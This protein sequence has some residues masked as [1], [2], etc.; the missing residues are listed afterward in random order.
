MKIFAALSLLSFLAAPSAVD[1][2]PASSTL[3]PTHTPTTTRPKP[4]STSSAFEEGIE[5]LRHCPK[6]QGKQPTSCPH[7]YRCSLRRATATAT[8][9]LTRPASSSDRVCE[10]IS[11][12]S[13]AQCNAVALFSGR[14][15]PSRPCSDGTFMDGTVC[16]LDGAKC[17]AVYIACPTT[18]TSTR[19]TFQAPSAIKSTPTPTQHKRAAEDDEVATLL[20]LIPTDAPVVD[21]LA[22]V[23]LDPALLTDVASIGLPTD[24]G[25]WSTDVPPSDAMPTDWVDPATDSGSAQVIGGE[26]GA[27]FGDMPLPGDLAALSTF[28]DNALIPTALPTELP[29]VV[30]LPPAEPDG[31]VEAT[32]AA[33]S[34]TDDGGVANEPE[35]TAA[36][37]AADPTSVANVIN[38]AEPTESSAND[39]ATWSWI[40]T[41]DDATA[42]ATFSVTTDE[43]TTDATATAT[44]T[45]AET[46]GGAPVPTA[47]TTP[48]TPLEC[49]RPACNSLRCVNMADPFTLE[50]AEPA[51]RHEKCL[52]VAACEAQA[53]SGRCGFSLTPEYYACMMDSVL[54]AQPVGGASSAAATATT[55]ARATATTTATTTTAPH[56]KPTK[57]KTKS[58]S[59]DGPAATK[60]D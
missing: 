55:A 47:A 12:C 11:S 43:F 18:P 56:G 39:S 7:G 8:T 54:T 35:V 24:A 53:V 16:R 32:K 23:T 58:H 3:V 29:F 28:L 30:A 33:P 34:A 57:T 48:S 17:V 14:S 26:F 27:L 40:A 20:D 19:L 42:T 51:T 15:M 46:A 4:T 25:D 45:T 21:D 22:S 50:C 52:R 13:S 37:S 38:V 31:T 9:S 2:A 10:P 41:T 1:A 5:K 6:I 60:A 44:F 49:A 59:K 36:P